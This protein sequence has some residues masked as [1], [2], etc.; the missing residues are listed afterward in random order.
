M[1]V[2][3][4]T[5]GRKIWQTAVIRLDDPE[6]ISLPEAEVRLEEMLDS[7]DEDELPW[8]FGDADGNAELDEVREVTD[9][10]AWPGLPYEGEQGQPVC[11]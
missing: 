2:F 3:E 1:A 6:I 4:A 9:R 10:Q 8:T 11:G 5:V 7:Y